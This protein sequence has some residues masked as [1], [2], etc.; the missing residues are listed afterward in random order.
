MGGYVH[1]IGFNVQ[2]QHDGVWNSLV[3]SSLRRVLHECQ[4]KHQK[5]AKYTAV[6]GVSTFI[7]SQTERLKLQ[8]Y[9][10]EYDYLCRLTFLRC[11]KT[12]VYRN[13]AEPFSLIRVKYLQ[14]SHCLPGLESRFHGYVG[15]RGLHCE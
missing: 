4:K 8:K 9:L 11:D 12:R 5:F 2:R 1:T 13:A 14:Q 7:E 15:G 6:T 10:T 3:L